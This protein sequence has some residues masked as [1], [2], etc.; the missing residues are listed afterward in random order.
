MGLYEHAQ[1]WVIQSG[2]RFMARRFEVKAQRA[3]YDAQP[4]EWIRPQ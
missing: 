2:E 3:R 1:D 4:V